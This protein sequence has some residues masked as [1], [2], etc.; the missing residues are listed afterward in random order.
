MLVGTLTPPIQDRQLGQIAI[1]LSAQIALAGV[2]E[3][4]TPCFHFDRIPL[5]RCQQMNELLV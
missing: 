2:M 4:G 1:T 3:S 5:D